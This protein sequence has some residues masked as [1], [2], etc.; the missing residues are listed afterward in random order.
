[1]RKTMKRFLSVVLAF[2]LVCSFSACSKGG[3]SSAGGTAPENSAASASGSQKAD[4]SE[5]V[6]VTMLVLG[7]KPTNGRMQAALA[8]EN[9]PLNQKI[10]AEINLQYIEWT[11]WQTKYQLALASGDS[12]IDLITTAT[13]WLYAWQSVKKGAFLPL[14]EDMLSTYAPQTWKNVS[15]SDWS[16]CTKDGKI[17]FIPEDQYTQWT[18]HGMFYRGD[19]AK[20]AGLSKVA[21]FEDLETYFDGV[22]KNHKGAVPWDIGAPNEVAG[23]FPGYIESHSPET[24][25]LGTDTGNYQIFYYNNS[26]PYKVVCPVFEQ[27]FEDFAKMMKQWGDKGF[28]RKNVLNYKGDTRSLMYAGL[29]G[30]DQH[31]AETYV[32]TTRP[33][34][35]QKQPGSD[36]QFYYWGM[37]NKNVNHD[38]DTH[39]AMAVSANSKH[40]ERALMV[41][42]LIRNDKQIYY[43]HNHGIQGKDYIINS[44]GTLGY[45]KG[46]DAAKDGLSTN[47]WAGRMDK[48]EPDHGDWYKGKDDL[49]KELNSVAGKYALG[50]FAF[51]NANVSSEMAAV[52]EVCNNFIPSIAYGKAGDPSAA[53]A[54]FRKSLKNAGIDTVMT[55]IQTQLDK[56]KS[57]D[58]K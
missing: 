36:L 2:A 35:E 7:N 50:K 10:N 14:T 22:L 19:W 42:D 24:V 15:K 5:H 46:F 18:C 25:I 57:E 49:Y 54:K 53:V 33:M 30:A 11:D 21:K 20:E 40:P 23:L 52:A 48:Y 44:D 16:D 9:K 26:D 32:T 38:L 56:Q 34:M 55:E 37:E 28:W 8:E 17:W 43:L 12:S 1:M 47:F 51:D 3:G 58:G 31:H 39:G 6:K 29:S 13:D 41:Y 27:Q 4:T 45:P